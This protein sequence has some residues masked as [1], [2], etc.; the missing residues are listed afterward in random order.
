[1]L[2]AHRSRLIMPVTNEKFV[3]KSPLRNADIIVLDLEDS[4]PLDRKIEARLYLTNGI[5]I[6]SQ[7]G[8]AV[9][10]RVNN[11]EE[12][13]WDDIE[14]SISPQLT[15]IYV[16]K[17]E[18]AEQIKEVAVFLSK[19]EEEHGLESGSI[20]LAVLIETAKGYIN[21]NSILQSSPRIQSVS[22]GAED[23]AE[24][25]QMKVNVSTSEALKNIRMQICI[26]ARAHDI[27][28]MGLM[29][30]ITDYKDLE[31]I[32]ASARLA[33]EHGFDGNSCVHPSNVDIFNHAFMP[34]QEEVTEAKQIVTVF[35]EAI[36]DGK[37]AIVFGGKMIDIPHYEKAKST[38]TQYENYLRFENEKQKA[39]EQYKSQ[40]KEV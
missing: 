26:A 11:T 18:S 29:S 13:L 4:I 7:G 10:V 33:Y 24:D 20:I 9:Y 15:G 5:N 14:A 36:K 6:A 34:G 35:E 32:R 23:F 37:A 27:V 17:V 2:H 31:G 16:P 19:L 30:S 22:L 38:L 12:L 1:M 3:Q 21:I 28:P 8:S 25:L 39:R 40:L